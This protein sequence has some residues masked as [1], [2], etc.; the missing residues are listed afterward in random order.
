MDRPSPLPASTKKVRPRIVFSVGPALGVLLAVWAAGVLVGWTA[1]RSDAR[2]QRSLAAERAGHLAA[3][4]RRVAGLTNEVAARNPNTASSEPITEGQRGYA[5]PG[6]STATSTTAAAAP[7]SAPT[8]GTAAIPTPGLAPPPASSNPVVVTLNT[9]RVSAPSGPPYSRSEFGS[10][11][12]GGCRNTRAQV[13]L[14]S[15]KVAVTWTTASQ[16]TVAT[17]SWLDPYTG[18]VFTQASQLDIDHLVPLADAWRSGAWTWDRSR[19]VSYANYLDDP[20]HLVAVSASANRSKGDRGPEAW[21]PPNQASWCWYAT[22]WVGVKAR[23]TLTVTV[24]EK[25]ALAEMLARC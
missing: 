18:S 1:G 19:R 7:T 5:A 8:S 25:S 16:C 12:T 20:N 24:P 21:R 3:L 13:L 14:R 17:G 22:S 9:L 11:W 2:T 23:W 10:G 15:T 6:T 4:E